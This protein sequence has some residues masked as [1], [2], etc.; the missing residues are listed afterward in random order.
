MFLV[1]TYIGNDVRCKVWWLGPGCK[2]LGTKLLS[3]A[4]SMLW[5]SNEKDYHMQRE[6]RIRRV[7]RMFRFRCLPVTLVYDIVIL[8]QCTE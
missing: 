2:K 3:Y 7:T 5:Y 8:G 1:H 6:W 4:V